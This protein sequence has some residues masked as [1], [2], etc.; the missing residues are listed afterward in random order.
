MNRRLFLIAA[1][2]TPVVALASK[3]LTLQDR[4]D[5][6]EALIGENLVVDSVVRIRDRTVIKNCRLTLRKGAMLYVA[7]GIK[8]YTITGNVFFSAP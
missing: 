1:I 6:G 4:I 7:P 3:P 8:D 5:S 2:A